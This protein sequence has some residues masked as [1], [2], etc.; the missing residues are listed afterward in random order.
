M[1]QLR[2]RVQEVVGIRLGGDVAAVGLLNKVLVALLLG[3]TDGV[4]LG[5]EEHGGALHHVAGRLPS[6]QRVLPSVALGKDVPVHPPPAATP[7][8]GLRGGL[9]GLE[10]AVYC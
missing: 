10:D 3:E 9:R 6:H 4:L 1:L 2:W 8:A 5:L 7:G